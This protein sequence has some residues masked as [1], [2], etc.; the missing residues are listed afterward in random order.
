M[1]INVPLGVNE[2]F[3]VAKEPRSE[4]RFHRAGKAIYGRLICDDWDNVL[5]TAN[6]WFDGTSWHRD[7]TTTSAVM[8]LEWRGRG[9]CFNFVEAGENP[10]TWRELLKL[11]VY[12]DRA[13]LDLPLQIKKERITFGTAEDVNL[14]RGATNLLQTDDA[15]KTNVAGSAKAFVAGQVGVDIDDKFTIYGDGKIEW[16]SGA[17]ARDTNLYRAAANVLKTDDSI[18]AV[19]T[20][21][22]T[23][24]ITPTSGAGVELYLYGARGRVL[25][26]DRS[27]AEF[28]DLELAGMSIFMRSQ[29]DDT[30]VV[31]LNPAGNVGIGTTSPSQKL[32]IFQA[33]GDIEIQI[34]TQANENADIRFV[35]TL[36]TW[37]A[38]VRDGGNWRI[39]DLTAKAERLAISASTGDVGIG[40]A[41]PAA[42]LHIARPATEEAILKVSS[43]TFTGLD[44]LQGTD[45]HGAVWN[46]DNSYIHFGTNNTERMRIT[47]TGN[48]GIGTPSPSEKLD[49]AGNAKIGGRLE[50]ASEQ[51]F[52][53]GT[54]NRIVIASNIQEIAG[55]NI[56]LHSGDYPGAAEIGDIII[57]YGDRRTGY[58]PDSQVRF[59]YNANGSYTETLKLT[60]DGDID[61][62]AQSVISTAGALAGYATIKVG[63]VQYKIALYAVS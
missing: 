37:L 61:L 57:H 40:T 54:A 33:T 2:Q 50:M 58:T 19:G 23:G 52:R 25:A 41:S 9:F 48:V 42:D 1:A 21:R 53:S 29:D 47:E 6:A 35:N 5:L 38:G 12:E 43:G 8:F 60:K 28:R 22:S 32:H 31:H 49:V 62:A 24:E 44:V 17:G 10:I 56:I 34:E 13:R 15:F 27:L 26:Y 45:G 7:V 16:G 59:Y 39:F 20:I 30:K 36:N 18:D 4:I 55:A 51:I 3:T 11:D 63:G 46:R 14:Y